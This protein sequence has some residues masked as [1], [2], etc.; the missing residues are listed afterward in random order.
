L[1]CINAVTTCLGNAKVSYRL[2][3][4]H[5]IGYIKPENTKGSNHS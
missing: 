4:Q 2:N 1:A 5:F 3:P